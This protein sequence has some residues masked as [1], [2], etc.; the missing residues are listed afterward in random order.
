LPP[1]PHTRQKIL[2]GPPQKKWQGLIDKKARWKLTPYGCLL[3]FY[4]AKAQRSKKPT[5]LLLHKKSSRYSYAD[6]TG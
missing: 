4:E 2:L 5:Q 3:I 1:N 6:G